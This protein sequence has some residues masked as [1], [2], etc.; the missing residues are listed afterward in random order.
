MIK[1]SDLKKIQTYE[2]VTDRE[3]GESRLVEMDKGSLVLRKDVDELCEFTNELM[4]T[5]EHVRNKLK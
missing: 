3:T 5:L 2:V 4:K 1:Y